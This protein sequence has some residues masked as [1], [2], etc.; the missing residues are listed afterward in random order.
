MITL[1]KTRKRPKTNLPITNPHTHAFSH[2][3]AN[4]QFRGMNVMVRIVYQSPFISWK[5]LPAHGE[6]C[7]SSTI[8]L[9]TDSQIRY[10]LLASLKLTHSRRPLNFRYYTLTQLIPDAAA[11]AAV[12]LV[13]RDRSGYGRCMLPPSVDGCVRSPVLPSERRYCIVDRMNSRDRIGGIRG[14]ERPRQAVR[15]P[16]RTDLFR[17]TVR[18]VLTAP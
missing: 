4:R 5:I 11:A 16:P 1:V 6:K 9:P 14:D 18:T 3:D 17:R 10:D 12:S 7:P 13:Y 2:Y 8:F 15:V